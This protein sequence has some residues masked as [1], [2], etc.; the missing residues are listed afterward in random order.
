VNVQQ[1]I[2][3]GQIL[4]GYVRSFDLSATSTLFNEVQSSK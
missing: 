4:N 1:W 3:N 2:E